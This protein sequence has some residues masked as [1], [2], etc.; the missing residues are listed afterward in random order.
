M[1]PLPVNRYPS[2]GQQADAYHQ[3]PRTIRQHPGVSAAAVGVPASFQSKGSTRP[4]T[5]KGSQRRAA[6]TGRPRCSTPS[7]PA[8]SATL[9]IRSSADAISRSRIAKSP[10]VA[11]VSRTFVERYLSRQSG[12]GRPPAAVWRRTRSR[13]SDGRRLPARFARSAAGADA[14]PALSAIQPAVHVDRR[15]ERHAARDGDAIMRQ[16]MRTIDRDLALAE[17]TT[18]DEARGRTTAQPRS[19][20]RRW[21]LR[22][23]GAP[24]GVDRRLW[25]PEPVG[26]PTDT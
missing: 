14:L 21:S 10:A 15:P 5:S 12:S 3:R 6:P 8:T 18:L 4:S 22:R 1:L 16:E 2:L 19:G 7:R 9:G 11:I 20:R 23:P 13:S 25:V 17:V 24:S 26:R